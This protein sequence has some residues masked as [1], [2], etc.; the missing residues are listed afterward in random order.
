MSAGWV[1]GTVRAAGLSERRLGAAVHDLAAAGS[2]AAA[3]QI[4]AA[5]PYRRDVRPGASL[6]DTEHAVAAATLWQLRVL[7][8]WQPRTG[9]RMIRSL[10][11]GFERANIVALAATLTGAPPQPMFEL[12]ALR[13]AWPHL[14]T[15]R[16]LPDLTVALGNSPWGAPGGD[17]VADIADALA[18]AWASRVAADVPH[19][20]AW[21][22]G[23]VALL[24]ARRRFVQARPLPE[25]I[26]RQA[27]HLLGIPAL[28]AAELPGFGAGLPPAARWA[29]D[30]VE[31]VDDLWRA[32]F[33]WWSRVDRDGRNLLSDNRFGP[34]YAIGA[35]AALTAD[36][37]RVRAAL[38]IAA[39]AGS[40]ADFDAIVGG[41]MR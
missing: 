31:A 8:G 14:R 13:W 20:A 40:V 39:G 30:G 19:A 32:E 2:L 38:Q 34:A 17:T 28:A 9:A 41:T 22:A 18:I 33:R 36:A 23:A 7:A 35:V 26:T 5:S 27:R 29:L 24:V 1:A 21:A 25:P 11:G 12:G 37:W 10:A 3:Q 6:A 16:S 15:A 4:L